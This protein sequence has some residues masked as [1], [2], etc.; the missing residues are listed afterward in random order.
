ML[1]LIYL[2]I[3]CRY[4]KAYPIFLNSK[5]EKISVKE[6]EEFGESGRS[7]VELMY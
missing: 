4:N 1:R 5:K 3:T 2:I 7:H 6:K